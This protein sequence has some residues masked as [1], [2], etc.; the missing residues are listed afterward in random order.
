MGE[1]FVFGFIAAL[2]VF[3]VFFVARW[4]FPHVGE[5]PGKYGTWSAALQALAAI[6]FGASSLSAAFSLFFL[7]RDAGSDAAL[8][9]AATLI[10]RVH[11]DSERQAE[12]LDAND[13]M[14]GSRAF[15]CII[16][17]KYRVAYTPAWVA[18]KL[19]HGPYL[20]D[21]WEIGK[22]PDPRD[23]PEDLRTHWNEIATQF[24]KCIGQDEGKGPGD[25]ELHP[26][27][28]KMRGQ[29]IRRLISSTLGDEERVLLEW[30]TLP[31]SSAAR[32]LI[33]S[34]VSSDLCANRNY[35]ADVFGLFGVLRK[36]RDNEKDAAH[37]FSETFLKNYP[38]L[39]QFLQNVCAKKF[40]TARRPPEVPETASP[41][42]VLAIG[43]TT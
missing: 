22:Q 25:G 21:P 38:H 17:L 26:R 19:N 24:G 30:P 29:Q 15:D 40:A 36:S 33:E 10:E 32:T 35:E 43:P 7:Q 3:G 41:E 1:G 20:V 5:D 16:Y 2:T 39:D 12:A 9:R 8:D 28:I 37:I 13:A 31:K 23:L 11:E 42:I 27:E 14:T 34:V 18:A 4:L 6:V